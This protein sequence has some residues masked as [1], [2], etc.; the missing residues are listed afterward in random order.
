M[1]PFTDVAETLEHQ[2]HLFTDVAETLE[3][4]CNLFTDVTEP[5]NVSEVHF[6][7]L[8]TSRSVSERL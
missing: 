2:C 8:Q 1:K 3:H 7:T 6:V 5:T 4:Q